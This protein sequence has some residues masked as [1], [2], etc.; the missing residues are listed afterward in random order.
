MQPKVSDTQIP[1]TPLM[2]NRVVGTV[3]GAYPSYTLPG[4]TP[5]Q[6]MMGTFKNTER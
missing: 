4:V 1:Q 6:A 5:S 2:E 3:I